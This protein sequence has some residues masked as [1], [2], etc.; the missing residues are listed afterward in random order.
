MKE[1]GTRTSAAEVLVRLDRAGGVPLRVQLEQ[2]L[3]EAIRSGRLRAGTVLPSSR[4]LAA[5]LG[6]SRRLVVDA[7]EQLTAEGYLEA[8]ERSVTRVG[9][10]S[11][12][13]AAV[14]VDRGHPAR[15]SLRP[16]VPAL[17][18]FPRSAWLKATAQILRRA[19]DAA[20]AYP[21]PRGAAP[22]RAAI[23]SYLR[24]VRG[25]VADPQQ[26]VIC[27]GFTQ[28][29]SLLTTALDGAM[30]GLED[31]GL[32]GR[33]RTIATA[34]GSH[35]PI[36]VDEHGLR[37]SALRATPARAVVVTPA[38]QFPLGVTLSPSRRKELVSWATA[39]ERIIIE[40]DYDAEFRYDRQPIGA[41]QGLAPASVAYVG[42][43]SKTLA[44]A[45]RLGWI[46]LPSPLLE[47][48]TEIK[49]SHDAGSPTL[50][51]LIL[52]QLLDTGVY[53]RHLRRMRKHYRRRRDALLMALR[54]RLPAIHIGGT[55]AGLHLIAVLPANLSATSVV[56]A[57][58]ARDLAID[59]LDRHVLR[60]GAGGDDRLV[61]GYGNIASAAIDT[62]VQ[63]LANAIEAARA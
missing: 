24:R 51:Q 46:V 5:D 28:A 23:A 27:A 3:R 39:G 13:D 15:Y 47:A 52:A 45:L 7:Y 60:A 32:V 18:E 9:R 57:A 26:V 22:L 10:V 11:A 49:R 53:E 12:P 42:T 2:A 6:V 1:S 25:V 38:H 40:D 41:L 61:L 20:L 33:D 35:A 43:A 63:A 50:D 48:V 14:A 55:A 29:L 17:A 30:V 21:D 54:V 19:P 34:G 4:V 37:T 62:A 56:Q 58:E 31:P 8:V 36:P 44:P 59:A 16:G